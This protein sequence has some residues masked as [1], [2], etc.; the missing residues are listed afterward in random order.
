[1]SEHKD[2]AAL[3]R[4][5]RHLEISKG[6]VFKALEGAASYRKT[7]GNIFLAKDA[8][9]DL[10]T[11]VYVVLRFA[12][13]NEIDSRYAAHLRDTGQQHSPDLHRTFCAG[14]GYTGPL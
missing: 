5:W 6:A 8:G 13:D 3:I 9:T 12:I 10:E 7:D 4:K 14:L 2:V 1:L 11:M